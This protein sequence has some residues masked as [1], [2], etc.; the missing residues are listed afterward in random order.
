[1]IA[2]KRLP[3]VLLLA[4]LVSLPLSSRSGGQA[5]TPRIDRIHGSVGHGQELILEGAFPIKN[6]APPLVWADFDQGMQP[7]SRGLRG[8]WDATQNLAPT[9]QGFNGTPGIAGLRFPASDPRAGK[10]TLTVRY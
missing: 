2:T 3:V 1:M 5:S 9:A 8:Q 7:T 10:W 4:L 6:P